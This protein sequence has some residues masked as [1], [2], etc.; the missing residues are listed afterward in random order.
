MNGGNP[1]LPIA[2]AHCFSRCEKYVVFLEATSQLD[3]RS[4]RHAVNSSQRRY[5]RRST[6]HT[7]FGDFW[8]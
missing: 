1:P 2:V 4:T 6:R 8:V 5:T 7:I 3:T